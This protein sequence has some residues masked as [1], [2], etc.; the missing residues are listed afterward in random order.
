MECREQEGV[1]LSFRAGGDATVEADLFRDGRIGMHQV[2]SRP[3]SH[4]DVNGQCTPRHR[5]C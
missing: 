1:L 5:F 4:C 2:S 3:A